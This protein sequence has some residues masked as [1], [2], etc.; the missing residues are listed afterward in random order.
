MELKIEKRSE[1]TETITG[2]NVKLVIKIEN[3]IVKSLVFHKINNKEKWLFSCK[4]LLDWSQKEVTVKVLKE[5]K[6]FIDLALTRL[7]EKPT[8]EE[9]LQYLKVNNIYLTS[10]TIRDLR[11]AEEKGER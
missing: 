3:G 7:G 1:Q 4:Q 8:V 9:I 2:K 11:S 5:L 6:Q 10:R